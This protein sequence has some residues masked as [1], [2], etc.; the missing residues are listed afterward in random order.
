MLGFLYDKS[1]FFIRLFLYMA[2]FV[3]AQGNGTV[4][5]L[6]NIFGD[7]FMIC[8]YLNEAHI[9]NIHGQQNPLGYC[10]Q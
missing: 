10:E 8:Q 5:R 2:L 6:G 9:L 4:L 1:S 3:C 7:L